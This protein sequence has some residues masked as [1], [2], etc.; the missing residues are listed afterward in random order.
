V[1]SKNQI[2]PSWFLAAIFDLFL[3]LNMN[4][5]EHKSAAKRMKKSVF[6]DFRR[7]YA[8]L[9]CFPRGFSMKFIVVF[10]LFRGQKSTL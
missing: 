6:V 10:D 1:A 8:I 4:I 2:A 5:S 7:L 9:D 3:L